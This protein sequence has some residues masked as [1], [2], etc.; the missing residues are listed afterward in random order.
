MSPGE[1]LA[2]VFVL[3]GQAGLTLLGGTE[4][5]HPGWRE[6]DGLRSVDLV[7]VDTGGLCWKEQTNKSIY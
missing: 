3:L 7:K 2:E 6:L 5:V 1:D 4:D